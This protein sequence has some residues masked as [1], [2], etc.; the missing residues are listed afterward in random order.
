MEMLGCKHCEH[1]CHCG[2]GGECKI[3]GCG[4][5]NCEHNPLD[6]FYKNLKNGFKEGAHEE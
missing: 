3:D 4:C 2:N 5:K 6:E 1:S